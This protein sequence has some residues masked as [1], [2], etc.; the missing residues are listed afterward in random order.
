MTNIPKPRNKDR[1]RF[2]NWSFQNAT[3]DPVKCRKDIEPWLTALFQSEHL[4]LLIGSGFTIGIA[5]SASVKATDMS[6]ID[7]TSHDI[8]PELSD[9]LNLWA[10][11]AAKKSGRGA[12]NIEDQIRAALNLQVGLEVLQDSR[13]EKLKDALNK[14]L[15]EFFSSILKTERS[16]KESFEKIEFQ[17]ARDYLVSFLMSFS[18]RTATRERL[19]V[20]T[21][22]YDRL[23]EFGCDLAGLRIID[24]FVGSLTPIF[25]S[26]RADV[27]LHY[28]PPGIR[29]EPRFLEGVIKLTKLHGSIDWSFEKSYLKKLGISFGASLKHPDLPKQ[30]VDSAI[31]YPN[32]AKDVETAEHP[33]AEL[34]RDFSAALCR[35][36]SVLIVYGYGFGD[37]HINRVIRDMLTIPSTHLVILSYGDSSGRI[38]RFIDEVGREN[39]VSYLI[40]PNFCSIDNLVKY[41]LPKPSIDLLM[42]RK[43]DLMRKR[44]ILESEETEEDFEV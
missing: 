3:P 8:E 32:P 37:D 11:Q 21:T 20:F 2:G 44:M 12:A 42:M 33:Y 9:K 13:S 5:Q 25:R 29:G 26:S 4:S 35:P 40:G 24:R 1:G 7:F 22:N 15:N 28:N 6:K 23:I 30:P 43:A 27:D 34:F 19:N 18:N 41:Y 14:I 10:S 36:N 39:Q 38:Q 17:S 31:I 16:I